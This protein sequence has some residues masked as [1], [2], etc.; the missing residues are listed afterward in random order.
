MVM[1]LPALYCIYK[2]VSEK[3]KP[4][5][6]T[7]IFL[8]GSMIRVQSIKYKKT[9]M[10][11]ESKIVYGKREVP[12]WAESGITTVSYQKCAPERGGKKC[13]SAEAAIKPITC[14]RVLSINQSGTAVCPPLMEISIGGF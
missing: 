11:R 1:L 10:K 2:R 4:G 3:S 9:V 7:Q 6:L 13:P 14:L 8:H 5:F 12:P